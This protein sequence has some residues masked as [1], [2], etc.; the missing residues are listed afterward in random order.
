[1]SD[2]PATPTTGIFEEAPGVL[3]SKRVMGAAL[4]A[5]GSLLLAAV[6]VVAIFHPI[7]DASSALSAGQT[8]VISGAAI[9]GVTVF[10]GA[11]R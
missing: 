2:T 11:A 9:L 3:S 10:Q 7:A 6:G 4:I 1:M 8:L 5:A